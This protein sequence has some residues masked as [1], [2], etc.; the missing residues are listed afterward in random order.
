MVI[1]AMKRDV[2]LWGTVHGGTDLVF[3]QGWSWNMKDLAKIQ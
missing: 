1:S 2:E 3:K